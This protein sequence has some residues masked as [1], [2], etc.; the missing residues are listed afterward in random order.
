MSSFSSNDKPVEKPPSSGRSSFG[1]AAVG[2]ASGVGYAEDIAKGGASGVARGVVGAPGIP[3]DLVELIR[4]AYTRVHRGVW[5]EEA[6]RQAEELAAQQIVPP[7]SREVIGAATAAGVPGLD[8]QPQTLPGRMAQTAGEMAPT[9]IIPGQVVTRGAQLGTRLGRGAADIALQAGLPGVAAEGA[10][11]LAGGENAPGWVAPAAAIGTSVLTGMVPVPG[12]QPQVP[13]YNPGATARV[14]RAIVDEGGYPAVRQQLD[15]LGPEGRLLD[16]GPNLGQQ[17]EALVSMPGQAQ[18]DILREVRTRT[19]GTRDRISAS[20]NRTLGNAEDFD[21]RTNALIQ[22]RRTRA[23]Q[24]YGAARNLGARVDVGPVVAHIESRLP[25]SVMADASRATPIEA[26]LLDARAKILNRSDVASLHNM[27]D[28]LHDAA[29]AASRSGNNT[30]ARELGQVRERLVNQ[31]EAGTVDPRSGRSLYGEARQVYRGDSQLLEARQNGLLVFD[32]DVRP[33]TFAREFRA[34]PEA[35][36]ASLRQGAREAVEILMDEARVNASAVRDKL[37]RPGNQEKL[38]IL[39]GAEQG[40]DLIRTL[41]Q[42]TRLAGSAQRLT[43]ASATAGRLAAQREFPATIP[44]PELPLAQRTLSPGQMPVAAVQGLWNRYAAPRLQGR[45]TGTQANV[46]VDAARALSQPVPADLLEQLQRA[47]ERG[48]VR[49][50][51]GVR[52]ATAGI[53]I[54]LQDEEAR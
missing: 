8:Y 41:E 34:L 26:A 17:A 14:N 32:R 21:A 10:R 7:T 33:Q 5:G 22:E 19:A 39:L 40:R 54:R 49:V 12:R 6:G 52:P 2:E 18:A 46:N 11:E 38:T 35:E 25:L 37:T 13:G 1:D 23:D 51:P 43:S 16:A 4:Q 44:Q 42:E 27:Q 36:R 28:A 3:G 24:L 29:T 53:G 20:V 15:E 45:Q 9:A 31:L 30:L 50:M 48:P 47:Y